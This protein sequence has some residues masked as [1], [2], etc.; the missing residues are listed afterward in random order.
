[1]VGSTLGHYEIRDRLGAGGMGE[2]FLAFD[3]KLEREVAL[4]VLHPE[5]AGDRARLDRF[6]REAKAVAALN[7][8]H[9][10]TI[11]SVEEAGGIHFLT[12]E[13]IRGETLSRAI[14][15][16]EMES[17]E[18]LKLA[19]P[20]ADALSV[21]HES[22][23]VH[24]DLKPAN[25]MIG[26][27]GRVRILDFGL[28]KLREPAI[29]PDASEATTAELTQPGQ[30]VGTVAYMSPEQVQAAPVDHRSDIFTLCV[31][32]YEMIVGRRPFKGAAMGDIISAI[33]RDTPASV[34]DLR[35]RLPRQIGRI[36]RRGLEKD[37]ERRYQTAKDLRNELQ[38]L[39]SELAEER[40][41][42]RP[43]RYAAW[44]VPTLLAAAVVAWILWPASAA[45]RQGVAVLPFAN[46][47]GSAEIDH[48][49]EGIAAS[50]IA[51][52]S[53]LTGLRVVGRAQAWKYRS[54][55]ADA[56]QIGKE[57][58]VELLLVGEV[59]QHDQDQLHVAAHLTDTQSG[60]VVWS[61]G[62]AGRRQDLFD[63]E[64]EIAQRLTAVLSI[65]LSRK[66]QR[67]LGQD[68]TRS[69]EA[70]DLYLR[71]QRE[72]QL[73]G[74]PKSAGRAHDLFRRAVEIDPEFALARVGTSEA[75]L[76]SYEQDPNAEYLQQA[77]REVGK[78]MD[79]DPE[80][81][82]AHVTLA[83]IYRITG[84]YE[85]SIAKLRQLLADHPKPDEAYREL[86]YS[87]EQAGDRRAAED[88]LRTALA[89]GSE[90]WYNWNALGA[91]LMA[92]GRT[93]EAR[94]VLVQAAERAPAEI[95]WPLENLALL[96]MLEGDW[97][98]AT[99]VFEQIP[100]PTRDPT[101]AANVGT[102]YFYMGQL[103]KAETQYRLAKTLAPKEPLYRR[104]LGDLYARM[105][106]P[107]DAQREYREALALVEEALVANPKD[108]EK[109]LSK[110]VFAAKAEECPT[111]VALARELGA[112]REPP[113]EQLHD[114]AQVYAICGETAAA[115]E[116]L[117]AA[118]EKGVSAERV[119]D[120]DEF[121]ALRDH[122]GFPAGC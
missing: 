11:H 86:A 24:R 53:E 65:P 74:D 64:Q 85:E 67:R 22:G 35:P 59:R 26:D 83:R 15:K 54:S 16:Q 70:Y 118:I 78:A 80:L 111:A 19:I 45:R 7:H 36:L 25:I 121:R 106:R 47:T 98:S 95:T 61:E 8:P 31:I 102:A 92:G 72:L 104:D 113:A 33:V 13:L 87:Y 58:G 41:R 39:Q 23:I 99:E 2:V 117:R 68:P 110:A 3:T 29:R 62:F 38:D 114:L 56:G 94:E 112:E 37:V 28:A 108:H 48:L 17:D 97:E 9:I 49:A 66:E 82:S 115:L 51:K 1:M 89:F 60:S 119:C 73:L 81:H 10:V 84:R 14:S 20:L 55:G 103:D 96:E 27:D 76:A 122:P 30:L 6:R 88:C 91:F 18:F 34:T 79:I 50:L 71:G 40:L 43:R 90:D 75:L 116:S 57:L 77:E 120:E 42:P 101:L 12:M 5:L 100:T 93:E 107:Q 63:L 105:N 4:K 32:F 69:F 109:R 21:A 52:L 44:A 46:L